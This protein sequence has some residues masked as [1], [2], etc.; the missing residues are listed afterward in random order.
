VFGLQ[1]R[2]ERRWQGHQPEHHM[3]ERRA[4]LPRQVAIDAYGDGGFRFDGMSHRGSLLAL[5]SGMYAWA[6]VEII[7]LNEADFSDLFLETETIDFLLI[8]TGTQIRPIPEALK[9]RF[10]DRA[11]QS[12]AMRTGDAI[13]T[14][15]ILLGERRRIAAAFFVV[16]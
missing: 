3:T 16:D 7:R 10:R 12:D 15:N 1:R 2:L 14:Y 6:P 11:M 9:W 13:R 4:H 8:G 5:P